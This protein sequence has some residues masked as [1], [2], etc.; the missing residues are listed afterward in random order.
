MDRITYIVGLESPSSDHHAS[1]DFQEEYANA[2]RT[3]SYNVFWEHVLELSNED[4]TTCQSRSVESINVGTRLSSYRIFVDHLLEPDQTTVTQILSLTQYGPDHKSILTE[5]FSETANA[6]LLCSLLLKNI[7]RTRTRYQTLKDAIQLLGR[8]QDPKVSPQ[9]GEILGTTNPLTAPA[10]PNRVQSI[11]ANSSRLLKRIVSNRNRARTK[12]RVFRK[13]KNGSATIL[14]VLT[15]SLAILVMV[16]GLTLIVAAP[17]FV[18]A[19]LERASLKRLDRAVSQLDAAAK[20]TYILK[21]DIDTISRLVSRLNDELDHMGSTVRFWLER[22]ENYQLNRA[23]GRELV[24]QLNKNE[25]VFLE[26]LDEL[27][28]HLYLCLMTINRA[29]NMVVKEILNPTKS[30]QTPN[31]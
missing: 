25:G 31:L 5:Y 13:L 1:V 27:E 14:V 4:L 30:S 2:F 28:E 29:R 16:H 15:A 18:M 21:R 12:L 8:N 11:Q 9:L 26:Q 7:D 22:G 19:V 23:S 3:E 17:C 24:T 20:G 6:S 10:S